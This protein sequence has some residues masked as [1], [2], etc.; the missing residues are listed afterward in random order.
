M[1]HEYQ[2]VVPVA[3]AIGSA[4]VIP[5]IARFW[6]NF[7]EAKRA[8]RNAEIANVVKQT[9]LDEMR[10]NERR[11]AENKELMQSIKDDGLRREGVITGRL[12]ILHADLK[13]ESVI[14]Q[15]QTDLLN[16]RIFDLANGTGMNRRRSD[17]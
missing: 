4:V 3:I 1:P 5:L 2:W 7:I 9:M 17:L 6:G 8:Q 15:S 16:Q 12:D 13:Q 11:H 14:R 10:G